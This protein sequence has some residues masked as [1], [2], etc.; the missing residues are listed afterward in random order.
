MKYHWKELLSCWVTPLSPTTSRFYNWNWAAIIMVF[1]WDWRMPTQ[2]SASI[3]IPSNLD[4]QQG[5]PWIA[6]SLPG[7]SWAIDGACAYI[8]KENTM[9]WS[10][11]CFPISYSIPQVFKQ[12]D[13]ASTTAKVRLHSANHPS[14]T[15]DKDSDSYQLINYV[16]EGLCTLV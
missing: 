10:C 7:L 6:S 12:P 5:W 2:I 11:V 13:F 3:F 14:L 4:L 15:N 8:E 16:F 1:G 9:R